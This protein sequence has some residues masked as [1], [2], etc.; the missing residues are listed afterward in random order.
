M[1]S[2]TSNTSNPENNKR[3]GFAMGIR[4]FGGRGLRLTKIV[5]VLVGVA[6]MSCLVCTSFVADLP[7]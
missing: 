7:A 2:H 6:L 1:Q 3:K 5:H 4:W